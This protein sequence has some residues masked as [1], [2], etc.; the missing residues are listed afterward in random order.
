MPSSKKTGTG[1]FLEILG[2]Y[3]TLAI[4]GAYALV[5]FNF[6]KSSEPI[7]QILNGTGSIGIIAVSYSK[8]VYQSVA[9][10]GVW[11]VIAIVALIQIFSHQT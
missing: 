7:Y 3:G 4:L 10:N 9:L 2:W 5:S 1:I 11:T 8:K 6:I